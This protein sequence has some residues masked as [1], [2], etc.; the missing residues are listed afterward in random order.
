MNPLRQAMAPPRCLL[1]R[2]LEA[3]PLRQRAVRALAAAPEQVHLVGGSVRDALLGRAGYDLDVAVAGDAL[4][5]ARRLADALGGAYVPLDAEHHV[6]RVVVRQ[7]GIYHHIDLAGLRAADILD[8]LRAR[9]FTLNAMAA[10]LQPSLGDLLDPTGGLED[11]ATHT[12]RAAYVGAFRDD[13]LRV[14]RGVRLAGALALRWTPETEA[15]AREALPALGAV[16]GERRRD[17][18]FNILALPHAARALAYPLAQGALHAGLLALRGAGLGAALGALAFLE[19]RFAC[20]PEASPW[21]GLGR[22]REALCAYW[23]EELSVGRQRLALLK[24]ALLLTARS[25]ATEAAREAARELRLSRQEAAHL[26]AA[27]CAAPA[28]GALTPLAVYRYYRAKGEG[29]VNGAISALAR[30]STSAAWPQAERAALRRVEAL[31]EAWFEQHEALVA[32]RPLLSGAEIAAEL[33][34]APGPQVGRLLEALREAQVS[35]AVRSAEQGRRYLACWLQQDE[36][37]TGG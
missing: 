17:E 11:L 19:E 4:S 18:L 21:P 13:P 37:E 27:V 15:L 30:A 2:W 1:R 7:G 8:D 6:A 5:L 14:L 25:P 3:D 29:G 33:G 10:P 32:P 24:L 9:D 12:L 35:G 22:F 28:E 26:R 36:T 20:A 34:I 31:L 16:S 23:R